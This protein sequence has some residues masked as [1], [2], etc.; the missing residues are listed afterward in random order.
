LFIEVLHG[1]GQIDIM[2]Q[3][4]KAIPS[5]VK[6]SSIF[7]KLL[8]ARHQKIISLSNDIKSFFLF[9]ALLQFVWNI[10]VICA[11][12]FRIM[13]VSKTASATAARH[14]I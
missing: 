13:I 3:E 1:S 9:V 11:M 10:F 4:L 2:C 6:S 14:I 8:V 5:M 12:G 7:T